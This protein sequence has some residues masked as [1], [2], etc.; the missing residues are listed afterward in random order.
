M[1]ATG[2][3]GAVYDPDATQGSGAL[4]TGIGIGINSVMGPPDLA[5]FTPTV[6]A[7]AWR[8]GGGAPAMNAIGFAGKAVSFRLNDSAAPIADG[9]AMPG[10]TSLNHTGKACPVGGSLWA[11]AP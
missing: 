2:Q 3:A 7:V 4:S 9:A 10:S 5:D 8:I 6:A 11:V 1:A